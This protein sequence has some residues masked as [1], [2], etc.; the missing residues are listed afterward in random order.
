MGAN[1]FARE[2]ECQGIYE[3]FDN[4]VMEAKAEYGDTSYDGTR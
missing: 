2:I 4:L 1:L 3:A